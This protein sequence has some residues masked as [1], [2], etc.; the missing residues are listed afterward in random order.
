MLILMFKVLA[1][2]LHVETTSKF[3]LLDGLLVQYQVGIVV[4]DSIQEAM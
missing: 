3:V 2:I 4:V 1:S